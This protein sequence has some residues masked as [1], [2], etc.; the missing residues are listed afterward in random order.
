M[1]ILLAGRTGQVD[2]ERERAL[3]PLGEAFSFDERQLA[4]KDPTANRRRLAARGRARPLSEG[5]GK[6]FRSLSFPRKRESSSCAINELLDPRIRGDDLIRHSRDRRA[7][8]RSS[9]RLAR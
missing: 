7:P 2:S 1:K 8:P 9:R 3:A 5:Q 4:P 6:L